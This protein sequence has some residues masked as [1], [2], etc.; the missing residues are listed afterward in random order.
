MIKVGWEGGTY[1]P[2]PFSHNDQKRRVSIEHFWLLSPLVT[3]GNKCGDSTS[4][5]FRVQ[6]DF[7]GGIALAASNKYK[8]WRWH[9]HTYVGR[10]PESGRWALLWLLNNVMQNP[11]TLHF[12]GL[13]SECVD[14]P[15]FMICSSSKLSA[16]K[17][18]CPKTRTKKR[19]RRGK[20]LS[21]AFL[22]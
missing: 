6:V 5:R 16:L 13:P 14:M 3:L 11:D 21:Q 4:W 8:P 17:Q 9:K 1:L 15:P 7:S 19:I 2:F 10:S 22:F 18:P 12:S 20:Y